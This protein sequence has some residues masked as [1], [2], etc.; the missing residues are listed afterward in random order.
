MWPFISVNDHWG[1]KCLKFLL[2][3][4]EISDTRGLKLKT[5]GREK[6]YQ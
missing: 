2:Y 3:V 5:I 6:N 1:K 4:V